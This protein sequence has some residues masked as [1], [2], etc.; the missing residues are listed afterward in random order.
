MR[1]FK[2]ITGTWQ[3]E[4]ITELVEELGL[5]GYGFYWRILEIIAG[6]MDETQ[7]TFASFSAKT[8]GKFCGISAKK[9]QKLAENLA[10]LHLF[11]VEISLK[12]SKTIITIDCP[13]L[14]KFKDE[15][16]KRKSKKS[17]ATTEQLRS[18]SGAKNR[19]ESDTESEKETESDTHPEKEREKEKEKEKSL[20]HTDEEVETDPADQPIGSYAWERRAILDIGNTIIDRWN[21]YVDYAHNGSPR[22]TTP[23]DNK[24][25]WHIK[26]LLNAGW[27]ADDIIDR[28][29]AVLRG[30]AKYKVSYEWVEGKSL[31]FVFARFEEFYDQIKA[32]AEREAKRR[33]VKSPEEEMAELYEEWVKRRQGDDEK[34]KAVVG[35]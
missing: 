22:R 26:D 35:A 11:S 6:N 17:R 29:R 20:S 15:W 4:K 1:W 12:N 9:F 10:E 27:T 25:L 21:A 33:Q 24:I 8:W 34:K 18:A 14:L 32:R 13:N 28:W 7:R 5:E 3:D 31:N 23:P 2:H 16:T 19:I 30:I